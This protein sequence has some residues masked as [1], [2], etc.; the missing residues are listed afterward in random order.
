MTAGLFP[1][2]IGSKE[3][4][5]GP[6]LTPGTPDDL[7]TAWYTPAQTLGNRTVML[8]PGIPE[9]ISGA[10]YGRKFTAFFNMDPSITVYYGDSDQ[11][12]T[13]PGPHA[14][15]PLAPQAPAQ[16]AQQEYAGD[17]WGIIPASA[18]NAVEVRVADPTA[19]Q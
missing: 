9:L 8:T 1:G 15:L 11:V 19:G 12:T 18:A 3:T 16:Y 2:A 14:G 6:P 17:I 13:T 10:A 5:Y 4:L 7:I